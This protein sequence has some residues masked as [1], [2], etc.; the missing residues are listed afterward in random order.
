MSRFFLKW[1]CFGLNPILDGGME[2]G[3]SATLVV[4]EKV[5]DG[6]LACLVFGATE[7]VSLASVC[8]PSEGLLTSASEAFFC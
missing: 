7:S 2:A 4:G 5:T 8:M 3:I 1:I 6:A